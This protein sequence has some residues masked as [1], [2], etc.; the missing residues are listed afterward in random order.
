MLYNT[1]ECVLS[2]ALPKPWCPTAPEHILGDNKK[3]LKL[4][5]VLLA[6]K[7]TVYNRG[8]QLYFGKLA[9]VA[10]KCIK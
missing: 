4:L 6:F 2:S 9:L 10:F 3:A 1:S 5:L 7:S 8:I